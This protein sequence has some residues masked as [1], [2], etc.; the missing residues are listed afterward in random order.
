MAELLA[1]GP[2]GCIIDQKVK[3]AFWGSLPFQNLMQAA[4]DFLAADD[5]AD[6]FFFDAEAKYL[7]TL[8]EA[9]G[10]TPWKTTTVTTP[11]GV[12]TYLL[13]HK[14]TQ[15][16]CTTHGASGAME[17]E[18]MVDIIWRGVAAEF[19][20]IASEPLYG[21]AVVTIM[22]TK[23][24]RGAFTSA[25]LQYATDF[26]FLKR[27]VYGNYD[28]TTYNPKLVLDFCQHG[29]PQELLQPE[30]LHKLLTVL[31]VHSYE[32]GSALMRQGYSISMGSNQ[33]FSLTRDSDGFCRPQGRWAHCTRMRGRRGGK[34]PG[35]AY[36]QSWGAGMP[37]GPNTVTLDSGR[38]LG[39][40]EGTFFIDPDTV[41][42][43]IPEGECYAVSKMVSFS[44]LDYAMF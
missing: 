5:D 29:V 19:F 33:G 37:S 18:Q 9:N 10:S 12:V 6:I 25:P 11:D 16:D 35:W 34:R 44:V 13:N 3:E 8:L 4:P 43:M 42:R 2:M 17:D 23:G 27:G 39:L 31:P 14:Q 1:E 36:G 15:S 40:P 41:N 24:D 30:A 38:V 20:P 7:K 22:K 21:G 26:G 28:L 32:E